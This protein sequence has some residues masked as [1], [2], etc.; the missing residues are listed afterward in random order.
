MACCNRIAK[1]WAE[2]LGGEGVV[3][4]DGKVLRCLFEDATKPLAAASGQAFAQQF[5]V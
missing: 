5:P 3:A 1:D 2:R 4:V